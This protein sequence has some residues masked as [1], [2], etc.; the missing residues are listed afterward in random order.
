V[1]VNIVTALRILAAI[2][3]AQIY[4]ICVSGGL[5]GGGDTKW[6]LY[7]TIVGILGMRMIL[8]YFFVVRF[9][10]GIAGAWWCWF[11]D[12]V[13]RAAIIYYRFRGGSGKR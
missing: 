12:Q 6:P 10:W 4:Q 13:A 11:L 5:R 1:V 8:G 3:F 9:Q 2:T 7:S